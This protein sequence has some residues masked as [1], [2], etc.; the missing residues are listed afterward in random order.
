MQKII[1][2]ICEKRAADE[3]FKVQKQI[4]TVE[5]FDYGLV[6]PKNEWVRIDIC[7]ECYQNLFF[8]SSVEEENNKND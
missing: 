4:K 2:D 3:H 8:K 5:F 1:C 6:F 7:K